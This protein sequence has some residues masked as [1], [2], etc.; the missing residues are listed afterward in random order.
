MLDPESLS[1]FVWLAVGAIFLVAG[2]GHGILGLGFPMLSTPLLA[3]LIDIRGAILLTLLPTITV[4]LISILRGGRWSESIGR[5][6]PLAL[7]IPLGSV[8]GTWLLISGDPEPFRLLLA[9]IIL[10]HLANDRLRGIRL[11]WVHTR[12]WLA[13]LL[14]G[15]AAGISAGTVNVMVPLLIIFALE[16]GMAPLVM[17]QV[18]NLCFLAGKAAQVGAFGYSGVL[19]L[20]LL[21]ATLPLAAAAAGGLIVGMGVRDRVDGETYRLWL[22]RVL[23]VLAIVLIGQYFVGLW[24]A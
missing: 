3:I 24:D 10:L 20:P 12:P 5:Y 18:F 17:V 8:L 16:L 22:R 23:V 13:Y 4:N 15:L 6:W 11:G 9:G 1:M 7:M 21:I 19:T 2:L 14:F